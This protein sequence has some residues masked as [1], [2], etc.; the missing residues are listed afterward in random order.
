MSNSRSHA[1]GIGRSFERPQ[2][3]AITKP[4]TKIGLQVV[5]WCYYTQSKLWY[6]L[7]GQR[8]PQLFDEAYQAKIRDQIERFIVMSQQ[9]GLNPLQAMLAN[10]ERSRLLNQ[11]V[12]PKLQ[13]MRV[14]MLSP[15]ELQATF[16]ER[17]T[18]EVHAELAKVSTVK[19]SARLTYGEHAIEIES[20]RQLLR[21]QLTDKIVRWVFCGD[22]RK[23]PN[24]SQAASFLRHPEAYIATLGRRLP[25]SLFKLPRF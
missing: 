7:K 1:P 17:I 3:E 6:R 13:L 25:E 15:Q 9:Q 18:Q 19:D 8:H 5:S 4:I 22:I 10:F 14:D 21:L 23:N 12:C 16:E 20:I 11:P 24:R 2:G